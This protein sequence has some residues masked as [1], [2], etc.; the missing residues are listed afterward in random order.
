MAIPQVRADFMMVDPLDEKINRDIFVSKLRVGV[1]WKKINTQMSRFVSCCAFL[2]HVEDVSVAAKPVVRQGGGRR[3][4]Y[5]WLR[6][7]HGQTELTADVTREAIGEGFDGG[8][9]TERVR[10]FRAGG[11]VLLLLSRR[12]WQMRFV[13]PVGRL[14]SRDC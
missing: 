4:Q 5:P 12:P 10:L 8:R 3:V 2:L 13:C 9:Q 7:G 6:L 1:V 14:C 11:L